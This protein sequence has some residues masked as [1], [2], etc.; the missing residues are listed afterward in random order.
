VWAITF[1]VTGFVSINISDVTMAR[2]NHVT[3]RR[4]GPVRGSNVPTIGFDLLYAFVIIRLALSNGRFRRPI[5]T[6]GAYAGREN[7]EVLSLTV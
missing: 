2:S 1:A 6:R 3:P 5:L 7:A 4:H